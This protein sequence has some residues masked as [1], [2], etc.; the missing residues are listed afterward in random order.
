MMPGEKPEQAPIAAI[1]AGGRGTRLGGTDKALLDWAGEA[2]ILRV[3]RRLRPHCRRI[4]VIARGD[5]GRFQSLGLAAIADRTDLPLAG[6]R[7]GLA[8]AFGLLDRVG[9]DDLL[10]TTPTDLPDLPFDLVWRL[11][12]AMAATNAPAA[13]A[14]SADHMHPLVALWTA[15][16]AKRALAHFA[17][18]PDSSAMLLHRAIGSAIA[19]FAARPRDPFHNVNRPEDLPSDARFRPSPS[20]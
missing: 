7:L 8:T 1:L 15:D 10:L 4:V 11:K 9:A 14:A 3:A 17:A 12:R 2:L 16:G 5:L 13:C 18:C 6:A 19:R 20:P